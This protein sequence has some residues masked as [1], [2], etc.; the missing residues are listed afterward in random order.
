MNKVHYHHHHQTLK[1]LLH[2]KKPAVAH[3]SGS[4]VFPVDWNL[5]FIY[6]HQLKLFNKWKIARTFSK[7]K[8]VSNFAEMENNLLYYVEAKWTMAKWNRWNTFWPRKV[9]KVA[10]I[11]P[12]YQNMSHEQVLQW[13]KPMKQKIIRYEQRKSS[14]LKWDYFYKKWILCECE[15]L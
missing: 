2:V 8:G 3:Y 11:F 13:N 7:D 15:F 14:P 1:G 6:V 4:Q 9:F 5:S 10:K 12:L